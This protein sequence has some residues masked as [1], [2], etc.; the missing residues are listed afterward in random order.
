MRRLVSPAAAQE[1]QG[2]DGSKIMLDA[3]HAE[4]NGYLASCQ[5]PDGRIHLVSS[6]NYY[7]FNL[8]WVTQP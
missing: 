7:V 2:T 8:S 5:G 6:R 1:A 3:T 4:L